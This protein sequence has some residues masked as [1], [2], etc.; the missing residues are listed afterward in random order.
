[1]NPALRKILPVFAAALVTP[2]EMWAAENYPATDP[3]LMYDVVPGVAVRSIVSP[4]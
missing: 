4:K 2:L 1:M 3:P